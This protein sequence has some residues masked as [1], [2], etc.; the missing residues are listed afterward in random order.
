MK[1]ITVVEMTMTERKGVPARENPAVNTGGSCR[2]PPLVV[3]VALDVGPPPPPPAA[4]V[5]VDVGPAP[6]PGVVVVTLTAVKAVIL[7]EFT[8]LAGTRKL[9]SSVCRAVVKAVGL[10]SAAIEVIDATSESP[11]YCRG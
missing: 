11:P 6:A 1:F 4:D 2:L 10:A 8:S 9:V 3:D 7:N 5:V